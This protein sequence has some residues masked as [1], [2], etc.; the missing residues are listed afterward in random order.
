[1]LS[2]R[3]RYIENYKERFVSVL[4]RKTLLKLLKLHTS[5]GLVSYI[6]MLFSFTF[7]K[8][9]ENTLETIFDA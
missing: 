3:F 1:M 2:A 9:L 4:F 7:H 8:N 5:L 6:L